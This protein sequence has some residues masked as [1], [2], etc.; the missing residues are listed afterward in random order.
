M[1]RVGNAIPEY[2]Y[3][4][5]G[6]QQM[7]VNNSEKYHGPSFELL[8]FAAERM[9]G[10]DEIREVYL[11]RHFLTFFFF[12]LSALCLFLLALKVFK[13]NITSLICLLM[14][15]LS[16]R[17]F[18]ESFYN[19]KDL[20]FLSFFTISL[21]TM[22]LF[23]ERN[24][25]WS[26]F[27]HALV[28]GFM[29]D[30]RIL[31]LLTP[32]MTTVVWAAGSIAERNFNR[33]KILTFL[34]HAAFL[35]S[36]IVLFWP[37]LWIKPLVHF[38][39][40]FAQ[41]REY[42]WQGV[43]LF[44]GEIIQPSNMPW[45]YL[46]LWILVSVPFLYCVLFAA[47]AFVILSGLLKLRRTDF[48]IQKYHIA[49]LALAAGPVLMVVGLGSIV[50]DSW[51]H[52]YFIYSSLVL[53]AGSGVEFIYSRLK[54]RNARIFFTSVISI[55]FLVVII[56]MI[57]DHPHQHV[58]FNLPARAIFAPVTDNFESDYWGLSY[59]KGL[60]R[61]LAMDTAEQIHVR[62]ENDPGFFNL[63]MLP[64][65]QRKRI[66]I[67]ADIHACDYWLAEFRGRKIAPKDVNAKLLFQVKNSS[68][69]LLNCYKGLR[70]K[71]VQKVLFEA[72]MDFEDS[73]IYKRISDV[74][75]VSGKY[76]CYLDAASSSSDPVYYTAGLMPDKTLLEIQLQAKI[77]VLER[78]PEVLL[79]V[80]AMRG[81]KNVFWTRSSCQNQIV[82][83]NTW[84]STKWNFTIP[85]SIEPGDQFSA[86]VWNVHG[87]KLLVDDF[88]MKVVQYNVVETKFLP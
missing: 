17:I 29:I 27:F 46:P 81:Q 55:Q 62:V 8:L 70:Q 39:G 45:Y 77:N 1:Q 64:P 43:M 26:A 85:D 15:V 7:L 50:Y 28:T 41:M 83:N 14:Y 42:P 4:V 25:I 16:P 71:T 52:L 19:S 74:S 69:T 59:R 11:L 21:Y 56:T 3:V 44:A 35:C 86:L 31:G 58:Y 36:F 68:G 18:G 87:T 12:W 20:A 33:R 60:E 61:I 63:I 84:I 78:I 24:N 32:V 34:A 37:V 22:H 54:Q 72:E 6:E 75:S 76:S 49:F 9:S 13:N 5:H 88:R 51:R 10:V 2:N 47:G 82:K 80:S 66:S 79:V 65:E 67:H 53:V 73:T 40:A 57:I 30:I 38:A 23:I 48:T